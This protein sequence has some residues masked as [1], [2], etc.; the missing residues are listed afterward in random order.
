MNRYQV[1]LN[2]LSVAVLD[3]FERVSDI[4]RSK[5]IRQAVDRL[6]EQLLAVVGATNRTASKSAFVSMA[7]FVDLRTAKKTNF[8]ATAD[9]IYMVDRP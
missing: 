5:M 1:Y 3:S 8:A 9:A 2:P 6:A 7:G 4:S